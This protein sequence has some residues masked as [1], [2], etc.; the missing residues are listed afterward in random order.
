MKFFWLRGGGSSRSSEPG[1]ILAQLL[2]KFPSG[3]TQ[4]V[5]IFEEPNGTEPVEEELIIQATQSSGSLVV[6]QGSDLVLA[7][8]FQLASQ[9]A[10]GWQGASGLWDHIRFL[11]GPRLIL[12]LRN[13][14]FWQVSGTDRELCSEGPVWHGEFTDRVVQRASFELSLSP[15]HGPPARIRPAN[16]E[17]WSKIGQPQNGTLANGNTD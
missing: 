1:L 2:G 11:E 4:E 8:V 15:L 5:E 10:G 9:E 12:C 16:W 7:D 17:R 6:S 3:L 13:H 14:P